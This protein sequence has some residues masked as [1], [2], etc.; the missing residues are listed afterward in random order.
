MQHLVATEVARPSRPGHIALLIASL[1]STS[2][3]AALLATEPV[4]PQRTQIALASVVTIGL[5]W[6]TFS[7]WVLTRRSV[8]LGRH[9]IIAA[10]MA[11]AF[12][13]LFAI[14]AW[15]IGVWRPVGGAWYGAMA[16]G[17]AMLAVAIVLLIRARRRFNEL[18]RRRAALERHLGGA[19]KTF[20]LAIALLAQLQSEAV[21]QQVAHKAD[22]QLKAGTFSV[23]GQSI[24]VTEGQFTV[25]ANRTGGAG[26]A[27]LT[28]AF[29]QIKSTAVAPRSPIVFLAGGPGDAG[30]RAVSGM[31]ISL[32]NELLS[33]SDVIAFD[34][35]GTGRSEPRSPVCAPG[36]MLPRDRPANPVAY[37]NIL[38]ARVEGC[39]AKAALD[40]VDVMGLTTSESADDLEQLRRVLGAD[41]ISILAGSYGT[42]LALATAKRH[43]ASIDRMVLAG[44][45]G[46]DHTFKLPSR[47]DDVLAVIA[48]TR[49]PTLMEELRTL[50]VRMVAEPVRYTFPAGQVIV[51]GEWDLRSWVAESLDAVPKIDALVAAVPAMHHG[52]FS[53]LGQWALANRAP[54]PINLM[55]LAIDCASYSSRDRLA[56]IARESQS[57]LL[58]DA[59]NF[60]LPGICD[61]KNLP[62]LPDSFRDT[63]TS[64][65]PVLLISGTFDG[66]TP[67]QNA[68]EVGQGMR[69]ARMLVIDGA[70]HGLFREAAVTAALVEFFRG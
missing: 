12:T 18:S 66:R 4:L 15:A 49:R 51:F 20:L 42:H 26:T 25:P 32:L 61:I 70:S 41:R 27:T 5:A 23:G 58:G 64:D 30:T 22:V 11:V 7:L 44:V 43:P 29:V 31:P 39:L 45:E 50:R 33:I 24:A 1:I 35:R 63:F 14:E 16:L 55:N 8:L 17:V 19:V 69:R 6:I 62:R 40:G 52:E 13:A 67:V 38:S 54:R 10:R 21:A 60:P 37:L 2:I 48:A 56:R 3:A 65:A 34:Q 53:A 9:R 59:I 68:V 46:L 28:L 57:A 36:E 47:V